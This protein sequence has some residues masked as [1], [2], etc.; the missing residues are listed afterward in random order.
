MDDGHSMDC[1][2][3]VKVL[4][5]LLHFGQR[6]RFVSLIFK[7]QRA[8]AMGMVTHTPVEG[9]HRAVVIAPHIARNPRTRNDF[10]R[11]LYS[12]FRMC[13]VHVQSAAADRWKKSNFIAWLKRGAPGGKLA[14]ARSHQRLPKFAQFRAIR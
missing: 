9:S 11:Y 5:N 8:A 12:I 10:A 2:V 4:R 13:S 14:V 6:H 7:V 1:I 3:L